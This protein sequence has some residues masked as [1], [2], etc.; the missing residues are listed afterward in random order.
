MQWSVLRTALC[1]L[2]GLYQD[3]SKRSCFSRQLIAGLQ[4]V[5]KAYPFFRQGKPAPAP[6]KAVHGGSD[7][8]AA[9]GYT[10]QHRSRFRGLIH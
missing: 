4:Q 8:R 10:P 6:K 5:T 1:R 2:R 9:R 7:Q 3:E